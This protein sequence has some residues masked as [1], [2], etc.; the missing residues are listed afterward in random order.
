MIKFSTGQD[1]GTPTEEELRTRRRWTTRRRMAKAA[2]V[3]GLVYPFL[4]LMEPKLIDLATHVYAFLSAIITVY[5]GG[6]T[7]DDTH[8]GGGK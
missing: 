5:I 7:Y 3:A 4:C 6:A 1:Q 2:F 8:V